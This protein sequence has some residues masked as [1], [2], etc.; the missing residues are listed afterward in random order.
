MP[1]TIRRSFPFLFSLLLLCGCARDVE[2]GHSFSVEHRNGVRIAVTRG[3]PRYDQPLFRYERELTLKE[4]PANEDSFLHRA[5]S[6]TIDD[7]GFVYAI[8][9]GNH[10]VAVFDPEGT[11]VSSFGRHGEGPGEFQALR[12]LYRTDRNLCLYDY[13]TQ[14]ATLYATD[15]TLQQVVYPPDRS[16]Y[17]RGVCPTPEGLLIL[18]LSTEPRY[19][20]GFSLECARVVVMT[21]EADTVAVI[22]TPYTRTGFSFGPANAGWSY[23]PYAGSPEILFVPGRGIAMTT[24]VEPVITWYTPAGDIFALDRLDLS[25]EPVSEE[26]RRAVIAE[27][28]ERV[29]SAPDGRM[30]EMEAQVRQALVILEFKAF[31]CGIDIDDNGYRWLEVPER[32]ADVREAGGTRQRIFSPDG[33]YLGDTRLPALTGSV[34]GGRYICYRDNEETGAPEYIVFRIVPAVDGLWYP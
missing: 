34:S 24:G 22:D 10:R 7:D 12:L 15:G 5:Y 27:F 1:R 25:P 32:F 4:D 31:W 17:V 30:R 9:S 8:D 11:Y 33:E 19:E 6:F 14:R 2:T 20:E 16:T 29:A 23:T 18:H 26:E 3:G 13:Q 28:D 21:A